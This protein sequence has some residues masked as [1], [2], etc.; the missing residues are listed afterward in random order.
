MMN[1]DTTTYTFACWI[2][3]EPV[4]L[5]RLFQVVRTRGFTVERVWAEHDGR[6]LQVHITVSGTRSG[7]MLQSQLEKLYSV[8]RVLLQLEEPMVGQRDVEPERLL[9]QGAA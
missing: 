7:A 9:A 4:G 6:D 5:E 1:I 8:Q 2:D 3:P